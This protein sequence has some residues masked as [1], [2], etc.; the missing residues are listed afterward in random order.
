MN[1]IIKRISYYFMLIVMLVLGFSPDFNFTFFRVLYYIYLGF[2]TAALSVILLASVLLF[3]NVPCK[4]K[5]LENYS[6]LNM[7]LTALTFGTQSFMLLNF[8][9]PN[10]AATVLIYYFI[11]GIGI[12]MFRVA[13]QKHLST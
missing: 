12:G 13:C 3:I 7:I 8:N 6:P 5:K 9:Y 4:V 2:V 10:L 11:L 1:E